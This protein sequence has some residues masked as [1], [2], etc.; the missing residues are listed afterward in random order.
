MG[1]EAEYE[2]R[3]RGSRVLCTWQQMLAMP[4]CFKNAGTVEIVILSAAKNLL[5][6]ER[7][8]PSLRSG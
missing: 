6:N 4:M 3:F 1:H 5:F 8:D 2:A 7:R